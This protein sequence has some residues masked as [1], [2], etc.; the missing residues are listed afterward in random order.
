MTGGKQG[1]AASK[2]V[3]DV[4]DLKPPQENNHGWS[5][6]GHA[7]SKAVAEVKDLKP[8]QEKNCGWG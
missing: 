7:A 5:K 1:H 8:P 3:A 2:T 4:K 6:Q